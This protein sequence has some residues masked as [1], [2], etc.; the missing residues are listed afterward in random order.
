M[1]YFG[2][3]IMAEIYTPSI[4]YSPE[5]L[6]ETSGEEVG[7]RVRI[8]Q[9]EQ[10]G[11]SPGAVLKIIEM[12]MDVDVR[13]VVPLISVPALILHAHGDRV[14]N[15]RARPMA[16]RPHPRRAVRRVAG[17]RS[18]V[19]V[20]EP[21]AGLDEIEEFLTGLRPVT[22][23]DRVLA[24]V[25]FTDIVDST[26]KAA[27][28]GDH[29][30]ARSSTITSS[31]YEPNSRGS[32]ASRSR[33]PGTGSWR[34]STVPRAPCAAGKRSGTWCSGSVSR[35]ESGSTPGRSSCAVRTW[36]GSPF[37]SPRVSGGSPRR[38]RSSCPRPSRDSSRDRASR[39]RSRGARP[40]RRSGPVEA[41]RRTLGLESTLTIWPTP[42]RGRHALS[43]S[44]PSS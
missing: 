24:T 28:L 9:E 1:P 42:R 11:A 4:A 39:S 32:A 15:V 16:R 6:A 29:A 36:P 7:E 27:E 17:Q 13:H 14:V 25:M 19:L 26:K 37:T 2:S 44:A 22:E 31:A 20:H 33:R 18:R 34:P 21:D 38:R 8:A 10:D 43:G 5:F 23:P 3:G 12:Y 40:Q 41:L 35:R 30:G